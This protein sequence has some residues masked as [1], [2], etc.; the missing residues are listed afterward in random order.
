MKFLGKKIRGNLG[1]VSGVASAVDTLGL[2]YETI[3]EFGVLVTKS[4]TWEARDGFREPTIENNC[5]N[6]DGLRNEGAVKEAEK[7]KRLREKHGSLEGVFLLGSVAG[8]SVE[9]MVKTAQTIAPYVDGIEANCGCPHYEGGGALIGC[10]VEL[11]QKYISAVKK[12]VAKPVVMK[13]TPMAD[14]IGAIAKAAIE[15]GA[16]GLAL[17]NTVGGRAKYLTNRNKEGKRWGGLSGKDILGLGVECVA[18]VRRA[19]GQGVPI[20]G[21]GG[22]SNAH[23]ARLYF[24]GGANIVGFGTRVF[25][26]RKTEQVREFCQV[27]GLDLENM[28]NYSAKL[29]LEQELTKYNPCRINKIEVLDEDLRLFTLNKGFPETQPGQFVFA[30]LPDFEEKP[31]SVPVSGPLKLLVRKRERGPFTAKLFEAKEGDELWIRGPYGQGFTV[32]ERKDNYLIA[33]G[34]GV[35]A[36]LMLA[37]ALH[38]DGRT[39]IFVGARREKQL[40]FLDEL[41]RYGKVHI[42]TNDGSAGYKGTAVEMFN[43]FVAQHGKKSVNVYLCGPKGMEEAAIKSAERLEGRIE[44]ATEPRIRCGVGLCDHCSIDGYR[45]CIDGPVFDGRWLMKTNYFK[46][47]L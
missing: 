45:G 28:T 9:D 17:I 46:E 1:N 44:V 26:G 47:G 43:D 29:N 6:A 13:M 4:F 37:R 38:D 30:Y 25:L 33:G 32:E 27:I 15:S 41:K 16:A 19:V 11:T 23:E 21:M 40:H 3:P 10:S 20:V 18:E 2:F 31:F 35:A 7:L 8:N 39:H 42:S 34:T 14:D 36:M 22:V 12:A 24:D 5:R